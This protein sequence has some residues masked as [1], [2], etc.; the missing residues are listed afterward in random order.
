M[1][2]L[3]FLYKKLD[4]KQRKAREFPNKLGLMQKLPQEKWDPLVE[5]HIEGKPMEETLKN[6]KNDLG[7]CVFYIYNSLECKTLNLVVMDQGFS[8]NPKAVCLGLS[9]GV[10]ALIGNVISRHFCKLIFGVLAGTHIGRL[11]RE[12]VVQPVRARNETGHALDQNSLMRT[13]RFLEWTSES[14]GFSNPQRHCLLQNAVVTFTAPSQGRSS[15]VA[16]SHFAA[17]LH[18]IETPS[19]QEGSTQNSIQRHGKSGK[20]G[21]V[22]QCKK[23]S[24]HIH[25]QMKQLKI[26]RRP[27][28][29][30]LAP[31]FLVRL[32]SA[33]APSVLF[34]GQRFKTNIMF[35][36]SPGSPHLLESQFAFHGFKP[37]GEHQ[38]NR[39]YSVLQQRL[40]AGRGS[41]ASQSPLGSLLDDLFP[42]LADLLQVLS[43]LYP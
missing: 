9:E 29:P 10:Y 2:H 17:P 18:Y 3:L 35:Q 16:S 7:K 30:L 4:T 14:G 12:L 1:H 32:D 34:L 38:E 27:L 26:A 28:R 22:E 39:L 20:K 8:I 24:A 37:R 13:G 43:L 5:L 21:Q 42:G 40:V 6:K 11:N 41:A 15:S 25:F 23:V 19:S 36:E 33:P 31:P